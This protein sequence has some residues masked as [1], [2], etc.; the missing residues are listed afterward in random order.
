M[1]KDLCVSTVKCMGT[2]FK[3]LHKHAVDLTLCKRK[4]ITRDAKKTGIEHVYTV[5]CTGI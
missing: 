5:H 4:I 2:N 1:R 3:L